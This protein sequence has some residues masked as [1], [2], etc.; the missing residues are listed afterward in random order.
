MPSALNLFV[1]L[2]WLL[3]S[4]LYYN[5]AEILN[6][7]IDSADLPLLSDAELKFFLENQGQFGRGFARDVNEFPEGQAFEPVF[8]KLNEVQRK[9]GV[10]PSYQSF[11]DPSFRQVEGVAEDV[12]GKLLKFLPFMQ[13]VRLY[14]N[15]EHSD[16]AHIGITYDFIW[17]KRIWSSQ[18]V[19]KICFWVAWIGPQVSKNL[20]SYRLFLGTCFEEKMHNFKEIYDLNN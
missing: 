6:N 18:L 17:T 4:D 7:W 10:N 20:Q 5:N 13:F 3:V 19:L 1:I 12:L 16:K 9:F 14:L 8:P 11:Y 15:L 2:V